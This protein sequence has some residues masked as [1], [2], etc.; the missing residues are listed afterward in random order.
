MAAVRGR[1]L[2]G[3][4]ALVGVWLV[5][6]LAGF[7]W[8]AAYQGAPG[9]TADA[10]DWPTTSALEVP[11]GP[12]LLLFLHPE[13]ACSRATIAELNRL[14]PRLAEQP[15]VQIVM[16]GVGDTITPLAAA[17]PGARMH[18]DPGATEARRFGATTSGHLFV[19]DRVGRLGF[20]GGIT[21]ARAH[22][23][24]NDGVEAVVGLLQGNASGTVVT[25][26]FG[27]LLYDPEVGPDA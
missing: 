10:G 8:L 24:P 6:T 2:R 19:Y 18:H 27:C 23:G 9:P 25:P 3:A 15:A 16:S 4:V 17:V 1:R 12:T 11:T 13:C 22:E 26:V 14:L 7:A 5:A 20:H 21:R